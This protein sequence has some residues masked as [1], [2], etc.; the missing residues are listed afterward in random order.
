[1]DESA[2]E[3]PASWDI[4]DEM[5]RKIGT[6]KG[7]EWY[8]VGDYG[9]DDYY[10]LG[11]Q[12]VSANAVASSIQHRMLQE[13]IISAVHGMPVESGRETRTATFYQKGPNFET[14][15]DRLQAIITDVWSSYS[16]NPLKYADTMSK[17]QPDKSY[18]LNKIDKT[19]KS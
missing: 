14:K 17:I 6:E 2:S 8:W 18:L 10:K 15:K 3:R 11:G 5:A 9:D 13:G 12:E 16:R 19:P 7:G 1:M 4:R